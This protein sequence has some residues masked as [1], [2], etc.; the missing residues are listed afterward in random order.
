MKVKKTSGIG[1]VLNTSFNVH[2]KTIVESPNDA[3]KVL[4]ETNLDGL[5]VNDFF[6][7]KK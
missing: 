6:V 2:G 3:I 4:K 1:A 7:Q 5:I